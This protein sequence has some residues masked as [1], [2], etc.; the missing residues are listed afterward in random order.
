M[1]TFVTVAIKGKVGKLNNLISH[2]EGEDES[3]SAIAR[4]LMEGF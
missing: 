2:R 4:I 1:Y 3:I